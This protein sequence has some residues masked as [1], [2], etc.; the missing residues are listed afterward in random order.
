MILEN[1][2]S[3]APRVNE[4]LSEYGHY[5]KARLGVPDPANDLYVIALVVDINTEVIGALTG[6]L[7]RVPGVTVKSLLTTK[8][9]EPV[10]T[11]RGSDT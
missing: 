1:E 8:S 10:Q 11:G 4:I 6:K 3:G 9:Y 2:R 5:I 7:G